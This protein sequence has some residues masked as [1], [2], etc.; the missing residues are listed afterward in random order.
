M[1]LA[2][3]MHKIAEHK[4]GAGRG[5]LENLLNRAWWTNIL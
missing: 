1:G 4:A 3:E 2:G 5:T